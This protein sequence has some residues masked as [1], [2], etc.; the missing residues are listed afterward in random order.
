MPE[1]ALR[2]GPLGA[3]KP[4]QARD[5]NKKPGLPVAGISSPAPSQRA[6][7]YRV[8]QAKR[9]SRS[10]WPLRRIMVVVQEAFPHIEKRLHTQEEK[11]DSRV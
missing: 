6:N 1:H 9:D 5:V 10:S 4:A 11:R 3:E 8:T 7:L 2:I